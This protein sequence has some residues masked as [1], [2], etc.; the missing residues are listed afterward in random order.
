M[1]RQ[2]VTSYN[3][4]SDLSGASLTEDNV[5]R[6]KV[7]LTIDGNVKRVELDL[8]ADESDALTA[9]LKPYYDAG[10]VSTG[11][12]STGSPAADAERNVAIRAWAKARHAE[13]VKEDGTGGFVHDGKTLPPVSDRGRIAQEWKDAYAAWEKLAQDDAAKVPAEPTSNANGATVADPFAVKA[14]AKATK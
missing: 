8:S 6:V 2:A 3:I 4:S 11:H 14:K 10:D 5:K 9:L 13:N 1:A 7:M 12:V